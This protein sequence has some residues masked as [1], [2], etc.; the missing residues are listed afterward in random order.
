MFHLKY[1]YALNTIPYPIYFIR[2]YFGRVKVD[3]G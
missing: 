3:V 2:T 1:L